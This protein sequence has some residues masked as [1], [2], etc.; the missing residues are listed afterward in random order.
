MTMIGGVAMAKHGKHKGHG[1]M[2]AAKLR[3]APT[4]DDGTPETRAR[5]Q[6]PPWAGWPQE[7]QDAA[8][9][10]DTAIRVRAGR[11]LA[12]G[13]ALDPDKLG[14]DHKAGDL[15][16]WERWCYGRYLVWLDLM[17]RAGHRKCITGICWAVIEAAPYPDMALLRAALR[18]WAM[19]RLPGYPR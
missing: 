11:G 16:P 15:G 4:V 6:P 8:I 10:M 14:G 17:A 3:K 5:L 18:L 9:E 7:L 19:Q 1:G 13:Q 12:R 2:G